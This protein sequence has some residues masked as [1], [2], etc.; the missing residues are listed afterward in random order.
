[1]EKVRGKIFAAFFQNLGED[2]QWRNDEVAAASRD[3]GPPQP[4]GKGAPDSSRFLM[5]NF[6]VCFCCY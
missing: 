4:T 1:M 6:N 3:G 5:I 2:K